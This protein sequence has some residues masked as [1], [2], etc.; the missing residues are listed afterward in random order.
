MADAIADV[1]GD[2]RDAD[3][4]VASLTDLDDALTA[5]YTRRLATRL[6]A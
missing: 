4:L 1:L 6:R 2:A 5:Y 3:T